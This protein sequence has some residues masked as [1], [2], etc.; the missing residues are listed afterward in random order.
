MTG[1]I[2]RSQ[3]SGNGKPDHRRDRDDAQFP[4]IHESTASPI[5][6]NGLWDQSKCGAALPSPDA[7]SMQQRQFASLP[8]TIDL[9][10]PDLAQKAELR[11]NIQTLVGGGP[12]FPALHPGHRGIAVS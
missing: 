9:S 2:G 7:S 11:L 4:G 3:Q 8:Q 6:S 1:G 5:W 12:L 10:E